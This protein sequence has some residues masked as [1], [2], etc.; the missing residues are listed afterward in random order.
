MAPYESIQMYI[1]KFWEFHL[2]VA[3]YKRIH[4]EGTEAKIL[5]RQHWEN[6]WVYQLTKA[7]NYIGIDTP[8]NG[9]F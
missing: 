6:E 5:F 1:E 7:K 3:I 8:Y 4:F 9:C 2:K